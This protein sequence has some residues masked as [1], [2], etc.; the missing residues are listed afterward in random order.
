MGEVNC[1]STQLS[2]DSQ[3]HMDHNATSVDSSLS[4]P[5]RADSGSYKRNHPHEALVSTQNF[6]LQSTVLA[7]QMFANSDVPRHLA[8]DVAQV[9]F[10]SAS[11]FIHLFVYL[12]FLAEEEWNV[13][14]FDL[15]VRAGKT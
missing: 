5:G 12:F 7:S 3:A 13:R 9:A 8:R 15:K 10:L 11:K 2:A 6:V 4:A 14:S 1:S